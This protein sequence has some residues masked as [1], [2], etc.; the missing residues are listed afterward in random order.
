M[1]KI[2]S[3]ELFPAMELEVVIYLLPSGE[4]VIV[5][6]DCTGKPPILY[7]WCLDMANEWLSSRMM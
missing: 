3:I 2:D 5:F 6:E 4:E 1:K 7:K